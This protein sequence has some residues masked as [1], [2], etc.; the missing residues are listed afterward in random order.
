MLPGDWDDGYSNVWLGT[1][2]EDQMRFD[3]RWPHLSRVRSVIKFISYEP[4]IGPLR[5]PVTGPYPD[6]M[7]SGGESGSGA[8]VMNPQWARDLIDDC[9]RYSVAAFHKQWGRYESNPLVLEQG[10]SVKLAAHRDQHGKGGG[11]IDG[12]L[13]RQFPK[14]ERGPRY[15]VA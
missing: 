14:V 10:L 9:R 12:S 8:R 5:L 11:L 2:A 4:A 1:T 13:V 3:Q 7:I 15:R 6:W